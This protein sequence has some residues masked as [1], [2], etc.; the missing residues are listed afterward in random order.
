[1]QVFGGLSL[2]G[3]EVFVAEQ[4][5]MVGRV[6]APEAVGDRAVRLGGL[7]GQLQVSAS[8]ATGEGQSPA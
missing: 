5:R 3:L 2:D 8:K 6:S 7:V 4:E 1:M